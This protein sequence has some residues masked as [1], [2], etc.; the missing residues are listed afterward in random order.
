MSRQLNEIIPPFSAMNREDQLTIVRRVRHNK[1][2][3]RPAL[4]VRKKKAAAPR[5]KKQDKQ[6]TN[7]L[8][9]LSPADIA[10]LMESM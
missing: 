5:K 2:V 1:Y 3:A 4:A 8:K 9:G 6:I 7:L 10:K